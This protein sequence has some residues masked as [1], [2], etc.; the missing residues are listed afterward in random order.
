MAP[1]SH[2]VLFLSVASCPHNDPWRS[3]HPQTVASPSPFRRFHSTQE[4]A[5][6]SPDVC[7]VHWA[8]AVHINTHS[9]AVARSTGRGIIASPWP[10]IH[11][12]LLLLSPGCSRTRPVSIGKPPTETYRQGA[13]PMQGNRRSA[14][15]AMHIHKQLS[16]LQ[17]TTNKISLLEIGDTAATCLRQ[18]KVDEVSFTQRRVWNQQT[19]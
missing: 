5:A 1:S 16:K 4:P 12:Q 14:F 11:R 2:C 19:H 6:R 3:L 13:V 8:A 7:V 18:K 9:T 10:V 15:A 17:P